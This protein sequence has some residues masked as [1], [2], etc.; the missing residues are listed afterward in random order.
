MTNNQLRTWN[1][2]AVCN[3]KISERL[4]YPRFIEDKKKEVGASL[5]PPSENL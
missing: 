5:R 4:W 2:T 3:T 1:F